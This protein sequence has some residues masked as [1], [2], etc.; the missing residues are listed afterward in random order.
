VVYIVDIPA[1][2]SAEK[3][4][5]DD[6]LASGGT[7]EELLKHVREYSDF[8]SW[9]RVE[10]WPNLENEALYGLAGTIVKTIEPNTES[11]SVAIL[12]E[13]LS[14]FGN[15]IGRGAHFEVEGD[16]HYL[17]I[18]H[19]SVGET[20][21][22]RKGT[23]QGRIDLVMEHIDR[24]WREYCVETGLSSGEGIVHRV[25]D[26]VEKEKDGETVVV[27]PGIKDKRLLIAEPE[28]AAPLT[29]MQREGNTLSMV[30]RNLWDDKKLGTLTKNNQETS[31]G[32]HGTIVGHITK[33]ELL[34]HLTEAKLGGGIAN[35]FLFV[36][37]RRSKVLPHGGRRDV[38]DQKTV[39]ALRK[40]A[41]FGKE[42]RN[43]GFCTEVEEGYGYSADELWVDVYEDLSEGKPFLVGAVISRAEA[44]VRRLATLYAVLDCS[45]VVRVS[46]LLA[47]LA[48]WQYAE[49]SAT[50]LFGGRTG[51]GHADLILAALQEN[52][53]GLNRTELHQVL[54]NN[55]PALRLTSLLKELQVAGWVD[56]KK[57][58]IEGKGRPSEVWF[59]YE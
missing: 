42:F 43:V 40:A 26:K 5:P 48:V 34:K 50:L 53:E 19:V 45:T 10:D 38:F 22:G 12:M 31:T 59:I 23:A 29:V 33:S 58:K 35:R 16:R 6:F 21:K 24:F 9:D 7:V 39:N 49:H 20:S 11:D 4:G 46:H 2:S 37:V 25:R 1:A 55:V 41:A 51:D 27:D 54:D 47:A 8:D 57:V 28:F 36:L 14:R 15:L 32:S 18:F 30:I 56:S 13:F 44:Y 52:K 3:Q 17:K